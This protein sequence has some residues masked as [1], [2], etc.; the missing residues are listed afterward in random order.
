[1][2]IK[3]IRGAY[4]SYNASTHQDAIYFATDKQVIIVNGVEYG[5]SS[6][7]AAQLED[8]VLS[9]SFTSPN[10]IVFWHKDGNNTTVTIPNAS[11]TSAGLMTAEM[12][13]KLNAIEESIEGFTIGSENESITI[14]GSEGNIDL[15][16]NVAADDKILSINNGI[17]STLN[18]VKVDTGLSANMKERYDITGINGTVIGSIPVY[19]DSSLQSAEKEGQGIKF[20]YLLA[21]GTTSE[22]TVDLSEFVI[23]EEFK[24]GLEVK[25]NNVY[26]KIDSSSEKYLTVSANGIALN[27]IDSAIATAVSDIEAADITSDAVAADSTHV[28]VDGTNVQAAIDDLSKAIKTE[29]TTREAAFTW[30]DL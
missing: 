30:I 3:F 9:V 18:V 14:G 8:A 25:S 17:S 22:V 24:D 11:T 28:A 2:N 19:K 29:E 4:N 21:D 13:N 1:M 10:T 20:T 15:S 27:G 16:V 7:L 23:E 26:V 12:V 6:E 5:I